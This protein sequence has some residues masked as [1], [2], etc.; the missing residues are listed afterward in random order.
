MPILEYL[1]AVAAFQPTG[2]YQD[3]SHDEKCFVKNGKHKNVVD[4][5][6]TQNFDNWLFVKC[7]SNKK[8]L[9]HKNSSKFFKYLFYSNFYRISGSIVYISVVPKLRE[10]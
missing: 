7:K 3:D 9:D 8:I 4:V 6:V 1:T 10:I 5:V 2:D